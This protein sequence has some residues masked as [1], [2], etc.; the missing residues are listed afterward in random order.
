MAGQAKGVYVVKV[1]EHE[2]SKELKIILE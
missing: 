2:K 1:Y